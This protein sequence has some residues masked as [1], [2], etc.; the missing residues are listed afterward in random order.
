MNWIKQVFSRARESGELSEEIHAHLEEKIEELVANGM[1]RQE[2]STAARREFGNVTLV[3]QDSRAIWRWAG[4]ENFL[5]DVRYGLRILRK[6]PGFTVVA[7]LTLALGIGANTAIFSAVNAVL[8]RPL[9]FHDPQQVMVVWHTPPQK[10]FPGV[11]KFVVSPANYLDWQR[12]NHVFS[13][14]SAMG[15][16]SFNVTGLGQPESVQG[17]GVSADFFPM[18]GV[19]PIAGRGFVAQD[20]QPGQAKVVVTSYSFATSHFGEVQNALGK[21]IKLDDKGYTVIGVMPPKFDFP[22]Q[23]A[24]WV[25][26]AWTDTERAV[27]GNHSYIVLARLKPGVHKTQAQA[28][29]DTIS[30]RLA[31]QYATDDAGWGALVLPVRDLVIGSIG[32]ALLVLMGAVSFVLLIACT[33]VAN[34]MLAKTLGRRKELAIRSILGASRGRVMRQV[35]IETILLS[36][37]GGALA[38]LLAHFV[39]R[40]IAGFLGDQLALGIEIGLDRWVLAFT[41]TISILT[42][43]LAGL[44]PGWHL[45]KTNLNDSLKQGLGKTSTD[46]GGLRVRSVLVVSE[47]ALSLVLLIGAGLMIRTLYF[48]RTAD[49]GIDPHNVLTVPLAISQTKYAAGQPQANFYEST[50]ELVRTLPGIVAAGAV[51]SVPLQ[52]GSTQPAQVEGQPI[53]AMADQPEVPVRQISPGY[54]TSMRIPL[55]QGRDF[56]NADNAGAPRVLLVSEAFAKRFWPH[57]NAVGKH[58]GLTFYPGQSFVV[59]GVVGNVKMDGLGSTRPVESIYGAMLQNPETQSVLTIRTAVPPTSLTSAVK[60]AVHRVDADEPVIGVLTMEDIVD[61]SLAQQRLSMILLATFAGLALLLAAVG[62]YGV[63]A[64]A[65]KHRVQ[66]IGIRMALGAQQR[67]VFRLVVGQGFRLTA[68]GIFIG[69]VAALGLTRLMSSQLY[70]MS[71]NDPVTFATVAIVLAVVAMAA[72]YIPSLR[73]TR[74]DPMVALRNE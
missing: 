49:P 67:D 16:G 52:G 22:F 18:L 71:P 57:D 38:F 63:Q 8:L 17:R 59:V 54:L 10:S 55:E 33:N 58:V 27:R 12:E 46:S 29:M 42:G 5:M 65:V 28:E 61:Q 70:E 72:C 37:I 24:L 19:S 73:A 34:L 53:Q 48:L 43:V 50:L 11:D 35:L 26:N 41:F 44:T 62:I 68:L 64:Y 56:T 32:P 47:V 69:L 3:E 45:T 40:A 14:M 39:V 66:E 7:V 36:V 25:P 31:Q 4:V 21:T 23:A 74:V 1:S 15:F 20:D 2:A 13:Q 6:S 51:D 9:P 30:S 60:A